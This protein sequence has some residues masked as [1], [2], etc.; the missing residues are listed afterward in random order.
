MRRLD[1]AF[2]LLASLL[3]LGTTI[4]AYGLI[5]EVERGRL[6]VVD[7]LVL[8]PS[9]RGIW[10][11]DH[12]VGE[13]TIN[14]EK[15]RE[16]HLTADAV[17][18]L[19]YQKSK[20][21]ATFHLDGQFN[22]LGQLFFS[23]FQIQSPGVNGSVVL[24]RVQPVELL[25]DL[26]LL[27][28]DLRHSLTIEGPISIEESAAKTYS[29][30]VPQRKTQTQSTLKLIQGMLSPGLALSLTPTTSA[31]CAPGARANLELSEISTNML[32]AVTPGS[33]RSFTGGNTP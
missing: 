33:L 13:I 5:R 31:A 8:G 11:G 32:Q 2:A 4:Y 19:S 9:S 14:L 30:I 12:C 20:S 27:E 6:V 28:K 17:L 3:S 25:I 23:K 22:P 24:Q 15:N 1:I 18:N 7:S 21:Q 10:A 26:M 16:Y 29:V